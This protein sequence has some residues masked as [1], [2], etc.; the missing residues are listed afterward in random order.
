M[1]SALAC[2]ARNGYDATRI[3]HIAEEAGVSDGALYRHFASKEQLARELYQHGLRVFA[4][5][6]DTASQGA[7]TPLEALRRM[8]ARVPTG[9]RELPDEFAY[10]LLQAPPAAAADLHSDDDL[11]ID[12]IARFIEEGQ[13]DGS[14]R[15]GDAR[16][17]AA[18]F[19]GCLLQPI[20]I[21]RSTPGCVPDLLGD[22]SNDSAMIDSAVG[23]V[24]AR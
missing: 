11:P 12:V 20:V 1:C 6:L 4:E 21:S 3:K 24:A 8:A 13:A 14:V 16:V 23:S 17:L 7:A 22:D 2:F 5:A 19:L 10:G 18:A 9:Y 15:S